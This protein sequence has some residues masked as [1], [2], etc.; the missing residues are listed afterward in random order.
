MTQ[1]KGNISVIGIGKLGLCFSLTL[2]RAGYCVL[3]I[4]VAEDYISAINNKT[5]TSDEPGVNE[6]L[7]ECK[8]FAASTDLQKAVQFSDFLYVVVATPSMVNGEYDHSQVDDLIEKLIKMGK[9]DRKKYFTVCC[10]TMPEYCDTAQ[11]RLGPYNYEVCYNPEFIAQGSILADQLKP[12]MVLIGE[13]SSAAG[14]LIQRHY[15]DMTANTP[16]F[17]KMS[18]TEA[19]IC[20]ISLIF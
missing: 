16:S 12:D 4:D 14:D 17:C 9:Q 19:E 5:F 20:K 18:R 2:E 11:E 7:Q 13:S 6:R 10:T 3:G 15:E 8:G 1:S